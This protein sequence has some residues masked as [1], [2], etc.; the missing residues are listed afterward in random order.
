[1]RSAGITPGAISGEM[2]GQNAEAPLDMAATAAGMP[3]AEGAPPPA[4]G[5]GGM[6]GAT[7]PGPGAPPPV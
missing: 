4:P 6:G 7:P 3:G 2:A 5:A 1:M